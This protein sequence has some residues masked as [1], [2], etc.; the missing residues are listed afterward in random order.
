[1]QGNMEAEKQIELASSA[2][3]ASWFWG[4]CKMLR[5]LSEALPH[6]RYWCESCM[7]HSTSTLNSLGEPAWHRQKAMAGDFR[8]RGSVADAAPGG[9][10]E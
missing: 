3:T 2:V 5:M 6:L 7:C 9:H 8:V 1:M 4:Y 10:E